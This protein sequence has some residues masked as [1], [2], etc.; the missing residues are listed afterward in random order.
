MTATCPL[1]TSVEFAIFKIILVIKCVLL[2]CLALHFFLN[3][4]ILDLGI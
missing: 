1:R 4:S 2:V 3:G